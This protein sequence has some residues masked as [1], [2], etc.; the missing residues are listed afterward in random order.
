M[1]ALQF[2]DFSSAKSSANHEHQNRFLLDQFEEESAPDPFEKPGGVSSVPQSAPK[3]LGAQTR[4]GDFPG[5]AKKSA[6][7]DES[8]EAAST[9]TNPPTSRR[10]KPSRP[11]QLPTFSNTQTATPPAAPLGARATTALLPSHPSPHH[12]SH[13]HPPILSFSV[14]N[15]NPSSS[16]DLGDSLARE[17]TGEAEAGSVAG[18]GDDASEKDAHS[19]PLGHFEL[20]LC[21]PIDVANREVLISF[22]LPCRRVECFGGGGGWGQ[23]GSN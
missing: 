8:T 4:V 3:S 23:N 22:E 9:K 15:A 11:P 10:K 6:Q 18:L 13:P 20:S 17:G 2:R 7:R 1:V 21:G 16:A 14:N 19:A 12:P 5:A